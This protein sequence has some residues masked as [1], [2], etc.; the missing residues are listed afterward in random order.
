MPKNA[1][2]RC[3]RLCP[4]KMKYKFPAESVRLFGHP[5]YRCR[6]ADKRRPAL[7]FWE[8]PVQKIRKKQKK[9]FPNTQK[10]V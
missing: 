6:P 7:P 4:R 2:L 10:G 1:G 5:D 9:V 3:R 8:N